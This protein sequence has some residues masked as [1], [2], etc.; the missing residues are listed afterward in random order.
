VKPRPD[1]QAYTLRLVLF[2]EGLAWFLTPRLGGFG[3]GGAWRERRARAA[4]A[5]R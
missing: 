1:P 2:A 5:G 4:A 3:A